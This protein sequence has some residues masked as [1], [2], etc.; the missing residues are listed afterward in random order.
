VL[1][2]GLGTSEPKIVE[3]LEYIGLLI[4]DGQVS[5]ILI[6]DQDEFHDEAAAVREAGL[7]SGPWQHLDSTITKVNGL[8]EHSHVLGNPLY[9]AYDTRPSKDRLTVIDVL[10]G[11]PRQ[12]RQFLLNEEAL[13][14]LQAL[15][16]SAKRQTEVRR[17]PWQELM[18]EATLER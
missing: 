9:S 2:F 5:N 6:K 11:R 17:L 7:A 8:T 3:F 18:D 1:Y 10:R 14:Y 15:S 13:G 12:D 4:S 16:L